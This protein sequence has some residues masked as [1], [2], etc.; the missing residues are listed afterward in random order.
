MEKREKES[1]I[2]RKGF[3]WGFVREGKKI[4]KWITWPGNCARAPDTLVFWGRLW[5]AWRPQFSITECTWSSSAFML[6]AF[7]ILIIA[8]ASAWLNWRCSFWIC[9]GVMVIVCSDISLLDLVF[10]WDTNTW[11]SV[12]SVWSGVLIGSL[13]ISSGSYCFLKFLLRV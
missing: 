9:S 11:L 7:M 5:G 2:I 10:S 13:G 3:F 12:A 8:G 1:T 6:A 4:S